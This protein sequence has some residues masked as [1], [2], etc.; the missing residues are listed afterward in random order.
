M[1][2]EV[3]VILVLVFIVAVAV[4]VKRSM[5]KPDAP[6]DLPN[7]TPRP[8]RPRDTNDKIQDR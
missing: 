8:S 7:S 3:L 5:S 6:K 4:A 2:N 1:S